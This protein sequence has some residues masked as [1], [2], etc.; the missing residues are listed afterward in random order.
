M[1]RTDNELYRIAMWETIVNYRSGYAESTKE[2]LKRYY[3][4]TKKQLEK[5]LY[6]MND[7]Y[8][9]KIEYEVDHYREMLQRKKQEEKIVERIVKERLIN[10]KT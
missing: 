4:L 2:D 10:E 1:R 3:N 6:M 9:S 7:I 5:T 8:E